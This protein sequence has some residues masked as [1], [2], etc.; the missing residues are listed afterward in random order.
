MAYIVWN[1]NAWEYA[2][3]QLIVF[4]V[5][6]GGANSSR[7]LQRLIRILLIFATDGGRGELGCL[8]KRYNIVLSTHLL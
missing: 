4:N 2:R 5:K 6:P 7:E 8:A 1:D 3:L